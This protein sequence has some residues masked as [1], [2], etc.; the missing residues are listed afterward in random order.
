MAFRECL[1]YPKLNYMRMQIASPVSDMVSFLSIS[2]QPL[3]AKMHL[4][5]QKMLYFHTSQFIF[6][7][8]GHHCLTL[9]YGSLPFSLS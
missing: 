5:I 8:K 3:G 2:A 6:I 4:L 1:G 9:R 7:W